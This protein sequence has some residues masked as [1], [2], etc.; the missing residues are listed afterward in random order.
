M[1]CTLQGFIICPGI[2]ECG[3]ISVA[4]GILPAVEPGVPPGGQKSRKTGQEPFASAPSSARQ[5][6]GVRPVLLSNWGARPPRAWRR[7]PS[8][9]AASSAAR[10]WTVSS[11]ISP[12]R[13]SRL[14]SLEFLRCLELPNFP[15]AFSGC[16]SVKNPRFRLPAFRV[17][18]S[19]RGPLRQPAIL[20]FQP[21]HLFHQTPVNIGDFSSKPP[22]F[23]LQKIAFF[24]QIPFLRNGNC[25]F[26]ASK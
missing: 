13:G 14:W 19:F 26:F 24:L 7:T 5:R 22:F 2:E 10:A 20:F 3:G 21:A 15:V 6:P 4:A 8:S 16:F 1:P 11:C 17:C 23:N 18:P 25:Q 12:R 9:A